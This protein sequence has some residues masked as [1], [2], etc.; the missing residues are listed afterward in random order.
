MKIDLIALKELKK[1]HQDALDN[2]SRNLR[3]SAYFNSGSSESRASQR[4]HE[5]FVDLLK[6]VETLVNEK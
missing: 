2:Y 1:Y 6:Q 3:H 4:S 5:R